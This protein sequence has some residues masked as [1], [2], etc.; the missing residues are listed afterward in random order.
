LSFKAFFTWVLRN[1]KPL[2]ARGTGGGFVLLFP[3]IPMPPVV[4]ST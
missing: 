1:N 4:D 2:G 3:V